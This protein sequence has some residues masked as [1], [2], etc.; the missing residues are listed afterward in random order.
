MPD[1]LKPRSWATM[2]MT[3]ARSTRSSPSRGE[4]LCDE[5]EGM[6]AHAQCMGANVEVIGDE[7]EVTRP[8]NA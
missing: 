5:V 2:S 8:S 3:S 4:V 7:L 1:A 6:G